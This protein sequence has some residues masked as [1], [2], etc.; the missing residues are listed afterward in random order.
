M[1][2]HIVV[3]TITRASNMPQRKDE[4]SLSFLCQVF[5]LSWRKHSYDVSLT[6]TKLGRNYS[7]C[8][9]SC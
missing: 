2:V 3:S 8:G 5:I 1:R 4:L 6:R 9:L 7:S